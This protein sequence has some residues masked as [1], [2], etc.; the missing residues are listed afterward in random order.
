MAIGRPTKLTPEMV[1]LAAEAV[2][3]VPTMRSIARALQVRPNTVTDWLRKGEEDD[4]PEP[5][6]SFAIAIHAELAESESAL[7]ARISDGEPKDCA[8]LLTHSPF[9]R[10]DW[11]DAAATRR[12]VQRTMGEV[13]NAIEATPGLSVEQRE[14]VLLS[15]AARGLGGTAAQ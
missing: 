2:R 15:L 13:V 11:S 3:K 14:A 1:M 6:R 7:V 5:F 12:E 10:D 4:A 9:F 8:W